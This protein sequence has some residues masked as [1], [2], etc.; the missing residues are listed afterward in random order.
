MARRQRAS[1]DGAHVMQI[2]GQRAI[3]VG[4]VQGPGKALAR[5]LVGAGARVTL[6]APGAGVAASFA[7]MIGQQ[8][9]DCDPG[10][11]AALARQVEGQEFALAAVVLAAGDGDPGPL[12]AA[13]RGVETALVPG[14]AARG[15]A[16]LVV[17]G[18]PPAPDPWQES[19]AAWLES[20][21]AGLAARHAGAGVRVNAVVA[22]VNEEPALPSFMTA[23]AAAAAAPPVPLGR[24]PGPR[25]VAAAALMLCDA[26]AGAI[27]GQVLRLDGGRRGES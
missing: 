6:A 21:V 1:T 24:L 19:C 23:G 27:T 4:G 25:D 26:G 13:L 7:A 15:G 20:A 3:V 22:L 5:A 10:D 11:A 17:L 14:L 9:I 18:L 16:L 2:S 8:G 12:A